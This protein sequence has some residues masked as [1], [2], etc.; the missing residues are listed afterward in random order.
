M[1]G[2]KGKIRLAK[3][4]ILASVPETAAFCN[5]LVAHASETSGEASG[6]AVNQKVQKSSLGI[7]GTMKLISISLLVVVLGVCGTVLMIGTTKMKEAVKEH[8]YSIAAGVAV[9]FLAKD[10]ADWL[11]DMFG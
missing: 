3:L 6:N 5:A 4:G 9:L 10:I 8:F 7:W 11:Q 1:E 2:L